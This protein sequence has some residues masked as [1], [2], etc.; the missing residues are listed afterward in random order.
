MSVAY[1]VR[2]KGAGVVEEVPAEVDDQVNGSLYGQGLA[3]LW[4][5]AERVA[6]AA[7]VGGLGSF[8]VDEYAAIEAALGFADAEDEEQAAQ[9][10]RAENEVGPWHAVDEAVR[11]LDAMMAALRR[12]PDLVPNENLR[13]G[14]RNELLS[15]KLVLLHADQ[16]AAEF[17]L[18]AI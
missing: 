5:D 3:R 16:R 10:E 14:L 11:D 18:I 17:R 8:S 12:Q 15:L 2:F 9:I 7:G 4:P 13:E 6:T 1:K